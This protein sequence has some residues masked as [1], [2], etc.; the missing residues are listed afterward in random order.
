MKDFLVNPPEKM[1]S[2]FLPSDKV[3]KDISFCS[4][5]VISSGEYEEL[6]GNK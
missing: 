2:G 6:S 4:C 3:S 5:T 1:L